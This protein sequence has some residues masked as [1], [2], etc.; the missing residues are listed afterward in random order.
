MSESK[1]LLYHGSNVSIER[2]QVSLNTGFADLGRGFYLT[3]DHDVAASRARMRARGMGGVPTVSIF[4]LD[5][6]CVPWASWG[7]R[8]LEAEDVC[9]GEPFGLRF[10]ACEQGYAAWASYIRSCR[11]GDTDVPG[12]GSPA[13]VRA[14]IANMEIEMVCTDF[15]S[16]DEFVRT[17]DPQGLVVQYCFADQAVLDAGLAFVGVESVPQR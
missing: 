12:L 9:E 11:R 6:R 1:T 3:D 13:I 5:E 2:P 8:G 17:V 10:D 7:D 14:W 4:S 16:V 15:I